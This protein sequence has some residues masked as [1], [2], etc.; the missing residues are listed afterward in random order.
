MRSKLGS[1]EA[2]LGETGLHLALCE[3]GNG[4]IG[5]ER[6]AGAVG[7][8]HDVVA[9]TLAIGRAIG[10]RGSEKAAGP[11]P[12]MARPP[13][14]HAAQPQRD[15]GRD[16]REEQD[17]DIGKAFRHTG[18]VDAP[19]CSGGRIRGWCPQEQLAQATSGTLNN[20]IMMLSE[21]QTARR[22]RPIG[23]ILL[24]GFIVV[25]LAEIA[26]L[27]EVGGWLGLGPT[28][29]LIILTARR[30]GLDAAAPGHGRAAP[31]AAADAAGCACRSPRCSRV[32]AW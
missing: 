25:P 23:P 15:E 11:P 20:H 9:G 5:F 1:A 18:S 26:V 22:P 14:E 16:H 19:G 32:F 17:I 4:S 7:Q 28:L 13:P 30:R 29:A 3:I 12:L 27:I 24:A 8:R 31:R 21:K 10:A 2:D 6:R